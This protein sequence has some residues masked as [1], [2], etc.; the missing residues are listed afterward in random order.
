MGSGLTQPWT[1]E[2]RFGRAA[3]LFIARSWERVDSPTV[4]VLKVS[5]PTIVLGSSQSLDVV[6]V[7]ACTAEGVEVVRRRSGG[8]AVWLDDD[9]V[10]VDVFVPAGHHRWDA[11][12]GRSMW[13]LGEA[14][15]EALSSSGVADAIVHREA[16]LR[17]RWSSLVCFAGVGAGEVVVDGRKV[18]G[19]SQRRTRVGALFQCGVLRRWE[20]TDFIAFLRVDG[21]PARNV[22]GAAL[23]SVGLGIGVRAEQALRA[24]VD[25]VAADPGF[26]GPNLSVR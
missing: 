12:I 25:L 7:E 11:D 17:T 19:I 6:D 1:V 8:G 10:W 5:A 20:P 2:E 24:F 15:A 9:M 18:V 3:D 23:E 21:G 14:W 22:I 4:R 13:W 26:S 16:I